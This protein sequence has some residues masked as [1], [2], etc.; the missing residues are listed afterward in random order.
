MNF[1]REKKTLAKKSYL[2]SKHWLFINLT[3]VIN[4]QANLSLS[5]LVIP[6]F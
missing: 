1:W 3:F 5:S 2:K 6:G 4:F